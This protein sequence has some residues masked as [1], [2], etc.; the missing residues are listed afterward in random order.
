MQ[1]EKRMRFSDEHRRRLSVKA[2]KFKFGTMKEVASMVTPHSLLGWHRYSV[3]N[4]WGGG[5][6]SILFKKQRKM[7]VIEFPDTNR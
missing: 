6:V 7:V 1:G 5:A 2:K 4:S 3:I